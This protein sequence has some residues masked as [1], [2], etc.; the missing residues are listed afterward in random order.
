MD[1]P[2][3]VAL[4]LLALLVFLYFYV[5][6]R[7]V[8][9]V[10]R[11]WRGPNAEERAARWLRVVGCVLAVLLGLTTAITEATAT[12]PLG[13]Y[14]SNGEPVEALPLDCPAGYTTPGNTN[15]GLLAFGGAL[16][17]GGVVGLVLV[18]RES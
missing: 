8:C 17:I 13:C 3:L 7:L 14:S 4:P 15:A 1:A 11:R 16:A 10:V 12:K 9:W 5:P 18:R 2:E 6:Y